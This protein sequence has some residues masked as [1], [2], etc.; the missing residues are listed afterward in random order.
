[1]KQLPNGLV[2]YKRTPVFDQDNLPAGLEKE[3]RTK[4]GVWGVI[5][6]LEGRLA[7]TSYSPQREQLLGPESPPMIVEPCE[8]HKV[9]PIGNVRFYVEFHRRKD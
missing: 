1:M 5:H 2:A 6:I 9:A 3:H 8:R 7:Y 4:P